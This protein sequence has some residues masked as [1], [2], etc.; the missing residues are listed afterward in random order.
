[1]KRSLV[2]LAAL[3]AL[4]LGASAASAGGQS[5]QDEGGEVPGSADISGVTVTNDA[6]SVTFSVQTSWGAMDA[7][8]FFAILLDADQNPATGTSGFDY[9]VTGNRYGGT[10][11]NTT[12]PLVL[13]V[14]SS[15]SGGLWTVTVPLADIGNSQA[16]D[17]FVL[18]Q[19]GANQAHPLEDRAP[20]T[21]T[22]Q[23][24]PP[25]PAPPPPPPPTVASVAVAHVGAP[26]HGKIFRVTGLTVEL[27]DGSSTVAAALTCSARLGGKAL[28]GRGCAYRLPKTAK[29]RRLVVRVAGSYGAT[30]L[31]GTYVSRVR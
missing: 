19:V 15:Y 25:A 10:V 1:M 22:W 9:V 29:G 30:P 21:G 23:Y 18:T 4:V 16:F 26:A 2:V 11:V 20:D 5:Y 27:S 12:T 8:T 17:F 24:P 6:S 3:A 28:A 13:K 31:R 14:P 7:N